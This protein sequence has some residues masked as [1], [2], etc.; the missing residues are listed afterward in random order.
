MLY[1]CTKRFNQE[2]VATGLTYMQA[3]AE[4][5]KHPGYDVII[6]EDGTPCFPSEAQPYDYTQGG[7]AYL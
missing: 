3:L 2:V 1:T 5:E 6:H 7:W 4:C